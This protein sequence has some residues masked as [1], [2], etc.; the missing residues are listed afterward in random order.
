MRA[1]LG[2]S[3]TLVFGV[4]AWVMLT[5]NAGFWRTLAAAGEGGA[6]LAWPHLLS[7]LSVSIGL[8]GLALLLLAVGRAT[9]PVLALALVTAAAAGYFTAHYG[10]LFDK[11]MLVNVLETNGAEASEL[12]SGRLLAVVTAFGILPALL[13]TRVRLPK[14]RPGRAILQR[15]AGLALAIALVAGPLFMDQKQVFSTARNHREL[16]HMVAPLDVIAAAYALL[17]DTLD[18]PPEFE[19]VATDAKR[20]M[21]PGGAGRPNVHVLVVGETARAASFA[22][23]GYDRDTTPGLARRG[24]YSVSEATAC[25]TATAQSLPCMFSIQTVEEFDAERAE[26]QDNLL[27]IAARAGYEVLWLDNGNN[28][29]GVCARVD[30]VDLGASGPGPACEDDR[31]YDEVLVDRLRQ[32]LPAIRKDTL[33]VLHQLGSH[34]PSYYRR[35]P[36]AFRHFVPDCRSDD[37]ADCTSEEIRNSYDNTILYTDHVV[38]RAIDALSAESD[39]LSTS[40]VYVSDHGESLGE[41]NLYLHG[42]PRRFAPDEQTHVPMIAWFSRQSIQA[43]GLARQCGRATP[44]QP[45][46][47]DNLFHTELGLLGIRSAAYDPG[48]DL[49]SSCRSETRAAVLPRSAA[50]EG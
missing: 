4:G 8:T 18:R 43:Q 1:I 42:M 44:G 7:F 20:V 10:I 34:G 28:C 39:R 50:V 31:C 19:P 11:K 36:D 37:L 27:D 14:R 47:H 24:L 38:S 2:R 30:T 21:P 40:L 46:S 9:R 3:E 22:L 12:V 41:H 26:H 15:A 48:L 33:I 16:A 6:R 13:V 5:C 49:F 32:L 35:Y 17:G 29:K 45:A 23:T 25:G